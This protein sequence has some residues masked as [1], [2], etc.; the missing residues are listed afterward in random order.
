MKPVPSTHGGARISA[1][2]KRYD[3]AGGYGFLDPGDGSPDIFCH[4]SV[5]DAVGLRF[6]LEGATVSCETAPG[7]RGPE[8]S[9]IHAVDFSA[10]TFDRTSGNESMAA[11]PGAV[12]AAAAASGRRLRAF[13]KWFLPVKGLRL[14]GA[15]GRFRRSVLSPVRRAGVRA[16]T[17]CPRG[18]R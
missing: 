1:S 16:T 9:R 2:V 14:P 8:V 6:L 15:G 12:P 13:V 4:A 10:A 11:G 5:L 3:A 18:R 7:Q 17:R